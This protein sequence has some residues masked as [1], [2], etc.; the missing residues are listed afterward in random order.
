MSGAGLLLYLIAAVDLFGRLA[1]VPVGAQQPQPIDQGGDQ[2]EHLL[3][4]IS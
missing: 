4:T 3:L 1:A 2:A